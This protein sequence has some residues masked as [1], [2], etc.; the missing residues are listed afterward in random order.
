MHTH[1][2]SNAVRC[3]VEIMLIANREIA[4]AHFHHSDQ[5]TALD[6]LDRHS[7]SSLYQGVSASLPA[8]RTALQ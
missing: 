4:H 3:Q 7:E 2:H 5:H 1:M 6:I 8:A